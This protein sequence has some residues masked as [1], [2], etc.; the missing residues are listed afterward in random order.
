MSHF[1]LTLPSNSSME[2]FP[3]NTLT[4]FT[5]KLHNEVELKDDWEMGLAEIIFP[6][7]L[8]NVDEQQ[9]VTFVRYKR[10]RG[11]QSTSSS[12][13][14]NFMVKYPVKP[15]YYR[16]VEDL[17]YALNDALRGV[18]D[19]VNVNM[20]RVGDIIIDTLRQLME[21]GVFE[22]EQKALDAYY[23]LP[24]A[25]LP[26]FS[27]SQIG[28]KVRLELMPYTEV[29]LS[30]DLKEIL[31]FKSDTRLYNLT[32]EKIVFESSNDFSLNSNRQTFYIYCD[33]LENVAVGDTVAPLL[34]TIDVEG[35]RGTMIHR[36]FEQP[37]YLPIQK[38]N[39]DS[40]QIDIRDGLGRPIPF[41]GDTVIVTLHLRRSNL[42]YF[43]I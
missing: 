16:N 31:G 27:Y 25:D 14:V 10:Q 36:N 6:K 26:T 28:N 34:R 3:N 5:T 20:D 43:L 42:S 39:F 12:G 19:P 40:V 11:Q 24:G 35:E 13:A 21:S 1:Y 8:L 23:A 32:A 2:Y 7:K 22:N 17:T 33:I 18:K 9:D 41:E 38:K 15:K 29:I 37:R 30:E 4:N